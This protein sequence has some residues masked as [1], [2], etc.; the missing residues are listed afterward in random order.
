M[1]QV[2]EK[3]AVLIEALPYI[4]RFRGETVV[5]KFGGSIMED[6]D[7]VACILR[8][9]A[10]MACVGMHPIIVH[11]GGKAIS[12][13]MK[14]SGL[15]TR[16][17]N[18]LRVTDDATVRIVEHVL[19]H[20]V[21]PNLVNTLESFACKAR[22]IHG[23]DIMAVVP[24][25]EKDPKTGAALNWGYVGNVTEVD[26]APIEAYM[27]ASITP[28]ITPL[29]RGADKHVYNV[30]ADEAAGAVA[31]ALKARK[32]VFLSD[33]PGLLEHEDDP[34]SLFSSVRVSEV[35]GLIKRGVIS[36]GMLP[37]IKG[38]VE[39][40][41]AGVQKTHIIDS[42]MPHSLLLELFTDRG[43]GTEIIA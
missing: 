16:F 43:V 5:V 8:D 39:T 42:S 31:R 22:G 14:E 33:V 41:R 4:Q 9:V 21:N 37:K 27:H 11:G 36:G 25:T 6:E 3:A 28:V 19:N 24:H 18:G 20:E 35:D 23:D 26:T 1:Q 10:F 13:S 32:L 12:R 38:A 7:G 17:V 15:P 40:L 30:N 29:G 34:S 2:I